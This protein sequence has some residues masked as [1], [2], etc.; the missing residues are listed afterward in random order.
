MVGVEVLSVGA[1]SGFYGMQK[2]FGYSPTILST[3]KLSLA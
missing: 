1:G 3:I 2:P